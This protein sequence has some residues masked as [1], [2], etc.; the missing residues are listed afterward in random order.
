[1]PKS[2]VIDTSVL[3]SAFLFRESVP[4]RVI[5]LAERNVYTLYLSPILIEEVARSLHLFASLYPATAATSTTVAVHCG[6]GAGSPCSRK[7]SMW[8]SIAW[9]ISLTA[10]SLVAPV[11]TQPGRS[12][13]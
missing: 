6:S 11:A 9:R 13:M 7:L 10:S 1:M 2:A 3:V 4:G 5:E 12:G 8:N